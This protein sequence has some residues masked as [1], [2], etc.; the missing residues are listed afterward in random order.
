MKI[1]RCKDALIVV[2]IQ[3]DF[4]PGGALAVPNG[5]QVIPVINALMPQFD[6]VVLT[7][8]WHPR[9]HMSFADQYSGNAPFSTIES[10]FGT[11]VLWPM[12]CVAGTPGADFSELLDQ[13]Y[14]SAIIR[15][16]RRKEV[17][18]YSAFKEQDRVTSTG[19]AGY[20]SALGIERVFVCGLALDYC[21]TWTAVD[22]A[23]AGFKS[24]ILEDASAAINSD[25]SLEKAIQFMRDGAVQMQKTTD[26]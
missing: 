1:D 4:L 23:A 6:T 19:L 11:Q 8:D 10:S 2:D 7:Q 16:G 5:H 24:I 26:K 21:V 18:S 22:A 15:K 14:A 20:L 12:H 25:G 13:T 17:D 3:R 9:N